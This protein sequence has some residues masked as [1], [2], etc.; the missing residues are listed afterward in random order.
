MLLLWS[1]LSLALPTSI[2]ATSLHTRGSGEDAS[3]ECIVIELVVDLLRDSP[4]ATEFCESLLAPTTTT[5]A[6][7]CAYVYPSHQ[8][9][10]DARLNIG[11]ATQ[12]TTAPKVSPT[13]AAL[14]PF[15]SSE[16]S[17]A[18]K[19]LS[20]PASDLTTRTSTKT[21]TSTTTLCPVPTTCGNEGVQ[22]AYY[23]DNNIPPNAHPCRDGY[24]WDPTEIKTIIPSYTST[25]PYIF[26]N[27][28]GDTDVSIYGS[29][30]T[31][32]LIDI[33]L[34]HRGYI[35]AEVSG[36]Y[37]YTSSN[38]D[39]IIFFWSGPKAFSG[40]TESNADATNEYC[41]PDSTFTMSLLSGQ[42]YPFRIVYANSQLDAVE[43]IT[44]TA[45]DGT[46]ILGATSTGSPYI[47]QY[48]CDGTSAPP[49]P[50]FGDES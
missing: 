16:I 42:Y 38:A 13:P 18:C 25:T 26:L 9:M 5:T 35:Y 21:A 37:T 32:D 3:L 23:Q 40:W 14:L 10:A 31:F 39:D 45:P 29:T 30:Q 19:C 44:I 47:V 11:A 1:L 34:N 36:D 20:I 46:V 4:T 17:Q 48:S 49:F 33:A 43:N 28:T 41:Q 12:I 24:T 27:A 7:A 15:P 8:T 50:A 2:L 6:T 22:W